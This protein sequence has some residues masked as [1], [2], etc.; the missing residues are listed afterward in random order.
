MNTPKTSPQIERRFAPIRDAVTL[1]SISRA[2]LYKLAPKYPG[3]FRKN[4]TATIVDLRI[5]DKL[6]DDLPVR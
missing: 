3:L 6:F 1:S 2:Q 4:G 5:L